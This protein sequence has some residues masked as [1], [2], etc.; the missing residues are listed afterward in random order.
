MES[1]HPPRP[2]PHP[3]SPPRPP[4]RSTA[5]SRPASAPSSLFSAGRAPAGAARALAGPGRRAP[6]GSAA[7]GGGGRN[8]GPSERCPFME[9]KD[10]AQGWNP[11]S[12]LSGCGAGEGGRGARRAEAAPAAGYGLLREK[13]P[14]EVPRPGTCAGTLRRGAGERSWGA[15]TL[16]CLS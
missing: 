9:M 15:E 12:G 16:R 3:L 8:L 2:P 5:R 11:T 14:R 6:R 7:G 1:R 4:P 10:Q 13:L